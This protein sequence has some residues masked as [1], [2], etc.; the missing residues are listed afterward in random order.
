[1][2][3]IN[4]LLHQLLVQSNDMNRELSLIRASLVTIEERLDGRDENTPRG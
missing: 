2:E 3:K 1:M 4:E